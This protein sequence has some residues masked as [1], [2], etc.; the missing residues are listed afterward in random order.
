MEGL[1]ALSNDLATAVDRAGRA[2]VGV[3]A[4]PR[5]GSTG[6][7]W[8]QGLVVTANHTVHTDDGITIT[9]NDGRALGAVVAARDSAID[10]AI[11][12]VD[13]LD[14]GTAELADSSAARVGHIVL[15]LGAGP[16]ASLG[17]ISAIGGDDNNL[18]SLDLTLY[19]GFSGGPLVNAAGQVLGLLTSGRSRHLQAA[20]PAAIVSRVVDELARR[21]RL[22]HAFLGIGTQ[23][24]RLPTV[25][26]EQLGLAQETAVI[27]VDVQPD[28]P[29]A[30]GG[31]VLGDIVLSFGGTT[32]TEP[33]DLRRVL[34]PDRVGQHLT[35]SVWRG[36]SAR[37]LAVVVAERA[38]RG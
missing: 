21:G 10:V 33:N 30:R 13:G 38:A 25:I 24:V 1:V 35:V 2:V 27:V 5:L 11:L 15:A 28:S 7:H 6:V 12:K 19:P 18:L 36:D 29:A 26:R 22:P 31:L 32:I 9:R 17:V 23:P 16:R 4:R 8:R 3:A 34:R 20:V 37:D 14:A